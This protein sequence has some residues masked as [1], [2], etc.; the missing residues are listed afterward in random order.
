MVAVFVGSSSSTGEGIPLLTDLT[1]YFTGSTTKLK[2]S[3]LFPFKRTTIGKLW[4]FN[5]VVTV[6][7]LT[8]QSK[9]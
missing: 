3:N 9:F 4:P 7:H 2:P 6:D 5:C 8:V 1:E